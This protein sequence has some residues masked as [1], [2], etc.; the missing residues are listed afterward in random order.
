[1]KCMT[2]LLVVLALCALAAS[3]DRPKAELSLDY[4]FTHF[5][6]SANGESAGI[7]LPAGGDASVNV[8]ITNF[9]GIVGEFS[10]ATKTVNGDTGS[11]YIYGGGVQFTDRQNRIAQP[12][13]K[14]V[15]GVGT[16]SAGVFGATDSETAFA[17][18]VGGGVD[19]R[20]ADHIYARGGVDYSHA[21]KYG[22]GFNSIRPLGGISF[23]F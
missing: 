2:W 20:L 4:E 13:G 14:F 18:T 19:I 9:I 1:M 17:F 11:I 22:T 23:K 15:V 12:F 6:V 7:N 16:L 5:W 21:T 10:G 8:P 3:Q